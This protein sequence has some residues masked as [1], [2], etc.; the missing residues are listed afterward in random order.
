MNKENLKDDS[1]EAK[2]GLSEAM[3]I[4][5]EALCK[6]IHSANRKF[7]SKPK[8]LTG[9]AVPFLEWVNRQIK[10][11]NACHLELTELTEDRKILDFYLQ[12]F[13]VKK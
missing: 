7:Q 13:D 12:P 8:E 11:D 10:N 9:K 1:E 4:N 5:E 6:F 3:S 2:R